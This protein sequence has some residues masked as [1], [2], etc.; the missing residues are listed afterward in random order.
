MKNPNRNCRELQAYLF[1]FFICFLASC[2]NVTHGTKNDL[3]QLIT[4]QT[5]IPL[6]ITNGYTHDILGDSILP[7]IS[8]GDTLKTGVP[9]PVK[10]RIQFAD[11][12]DEP[13]IVTA[14]TTVRMAAYNNIHALPT[15]LVEK[16]V[17]EGM[18]KKINFGEG[19]QSFFLVNSSG[20]TISTGIP[21]Q[22]KL[23][24]TPCQQPT[25]I[26][27]LPPHMKENA[28]Y[29]IQY[30]DLE[31]GMNNSNITSILQDQ[32]GNFWFG[33]YVGGVC[34]YDG[35]T[36]MQYT[37][38]NGLSNDYITCI[39]EDR[40]GNL[41][42]GTHGGGVTRFDGNSFASFTEK[43]G[44]PSNF[45][46]SIIE[47]NQGN[48]WFAS[49]DKGVSCYHPPKKNQPGTIIH[50]ST[51]EG[52]LDENI[53]AILE[54][55]YGNIWFGSQ[56]WGAIRFDLPQNGHAGSF[57]YY[58]EN[59]GLSSNNIVSLMQDKKGNLWFGTRNSGIC[60]FDGISMTQLSENEGL[61][62]NLIRS[63]YEDRNEN[64]WIGTAGGGVSR[65]DGRSFTTF[66]EQD[67]MSNNFI[68]AICED[69][70]GN[71]WFGTYG[72][73]VCRYNEKSFVHFTSNVGTTQNKTNAIHEDKNGKLWFGTTGDGVIS[74]E[75][76]N[77]TKEA[78]FTHYTTNEG[79]PSNDIWC[80]GEDQQGNLWFGTY[81]FGACKFG[82][83]AFTNYTVRN[84]L[85]DNDVRCVYPD[86]KGNI[87][88]GTQNGGVTC[89]EPSDK[90]HG[91]LFVK[92]TTKEG[93]P[94][95]SVR[96]ILEDTKGNMWFG[97]FAG[98]T[99]FEISEDNHSGLF[100]YYTTR[101]G[102]AF[103][104]VNS[105]IEDR[106][107]NL[108]FGT[109]RGVNRYKP[110]E[111]KTGGELIFFGP[112][113]GLS[114]GYVRSLL[115]D[116]TGNIWASTAAGLNMIPVD[117]GTQTP[118]QIIP[119]YKPSGLK[120]IEFE[121]NSAL[122]DRKNQLWWGNEKCVE[123]LDIKKFKLS[124]SV[125]SP[126]LRHIEIN[127]KFINF[128]TLPDSLKHNIIY[129][130]VA[131]FENYPLDLELPFSANH[132]TFHFSAID[133]S[134][135][136]DIR[137]SYILKGLDT[138]WSIPSAETQAEYRS[139]P[140]GKF[141]LKVC[142]YGRSQAWSDPFEYSFVI[143]PPWWIRWWAYLVY[144]AIGFSLIYVIYRFQLNRRLE[145]AENKRLLELD[146]LKNKL[147]TNITHEFRTPLTLIH[148]PLSHALSSHSAL[149]ENDMKS[150]YKQSQQ[151]QQLITQMLDL[152]KV[153]AGKLKP[154]YIYAEISGFIRYLFDAFASLARERDV[155]LVFSSIP[156]EIRMDIDEEK[157]TQIVSNL[158]SNAIKHTPKNGSVSLTLSTSQAG[159][160]LWMI[161][162]DTGV[163]ID[164]EE[165]PL[166][167]DR[168]Y[169]SSR[170][171]QGGTGIGLALTKSLVELLKG[172]IIVNSKPDEGTSFKIVL[173]ITSRASQTSESLVTKTKLAIEGH[174]DETRFSSPLQVLSDKPIVLIVEDHPE[175]AQY[176][177]SCLAKDFTTMISPD[178]DE[179]IKYAFEY[180]PD[181]IISDIMMPS[182]DGFELC[183]TLKKDIRT[184][185]IPII[186]LTGRGDQPALMKGIE[187]GAD[188]Y[189]IKPFEPAELILRVEKLLELRSNLSQY[190]R[191]YP[192]GVQSE[193]TSKASPKENE[194]LNKLRTFI[195]EQ[196]NNPQFN[197]NMLSKHMAMS[198]PQLHRKITA[199]TGESTGKFVR[200]VRLAKAIELLKNSDLTISE[201]AYETGFSEPG[202]FTKTFSKEYNMTPSEYRGSLS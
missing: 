2:N 149:E 44:M 199:L 82:G 26:P 11:S 166:I 159:D 47:D 20:D 6:N 71:M 161:V 18:L 37:V 178:G 131:P 16:Q 147:Y 70:N 64:T 163:G 21:I 157:L 103:N 55:K 38:R 45:I 145:L 128:R 125:P 116:N 61:S 152:Q 162:Q 142:S 67:G 49:R 24:L 52:L 13:K 74:Y 200:S 1:G 41:W 59:D 119:F 196:I 97:T 122:V 30:L 78:T 176:I 65:F 14:G 31:E 88:F 136:F 42:F 96:T 144:G 126:E 191:Q 127:G 8:M 155:T 34:R 150:M 57:T 189:V 148:G 66:K 186:L 177:A 181:L 72:G 39:L 160:K 98:V 4:P 110:F 83:K 79:L 54:D 27:A 112:K 12:L 56:K 48:L 81:G 19:P 108:W 50:Y 87:W 95:N 28:I 100:T 188:A 130:G 86:K 33:S 104:I 141:T 184:S 15:H 102:L 154:Q 179:G 135:P 92:Y 76:P 89:Y 156:H 175:V 63:L 167:F 75:P 139:L 120:G 180:V 158:V 192:V 35:T 36:F 121:F 107:G 173:P 170:A 193:S 194:F 164:P 17:N 9:I 3:P 201:I 46:N 25:P 190:Y 172:H 40:Y 111:D 132:L 118:S 174:D 10:G 114:S 146:N 85:S 123:M 105:I 99:K 153:E 187:H 7:L 143:H 165:L 137:Y 93:L 117:K 169:Q 60:R 69:N 140:P 197:M 53:N 32:E 134:A 109:G 23:R 5:P 185:H 138:S 91:G 195:E 168:Y 115:E 29:D 151:L 101:E 202:Y 73:G 68:R 183:A 22:I 106:S 58:T 129:S 80:I 171:A 198:H 62:S 182:K 43:E 90:K 133:W 77:R 51:K 94:S 84:G 113:S 124:S